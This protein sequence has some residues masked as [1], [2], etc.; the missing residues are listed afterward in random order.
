MK[1][2]PIK[3][4]LSD[5]QKIVLNYI[6]CKKSDIKLNLLSWVKKMD[7]LG[8]WNEYK[9]PYFIP[10]EINHWE[11]IKDKLYLKTKLL[12]PHID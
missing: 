7:D 10:I 11:L 6:L 9:K 4:S 1:N 5:E 3:S 8:Y 2:L 12:P